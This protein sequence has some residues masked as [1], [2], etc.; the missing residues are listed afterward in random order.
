M[1]FFR[2]LVSSRALLV[3]LFLGWRL[4]PRS[5]NPSEACPQWLGL[6]ET[7]LCSASR[8]GP[9]QRLLGATSTS[10]VTTPRGQ[11][12][13]HPLKRQPGHEI[14][15]DVPWQWGWAGKCH[16]QF[17]SARQVRQPSRVL[18]S[19]PSHSSN[20]RLNQLGKR[21]VDCTVSKHS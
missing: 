3:V 11:A 20:I 9:T 1:V 16:G 18:Q 6:L 8:E 14:L 5:S 12:G 17:L 4:R 19:A 15:S 21:L 10:A 2:M 13:E 7:A